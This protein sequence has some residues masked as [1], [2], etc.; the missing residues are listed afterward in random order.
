METSLRLS[1]TDVV[2]HLRTNLDLSGFRTSGRLLLFNSF[3]FADSF[4]DQKFE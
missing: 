1:S 3:V 2:N 4:P